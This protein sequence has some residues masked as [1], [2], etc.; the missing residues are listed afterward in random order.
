MKP[1]SLNFSLIRN[2][3]GQLLFTT[4]EG[5]AHTGI[6]PVRA[7]PISAPDNGLSLFTSNGH[8]L[9][10]LPSLDGLAA[11]IHTL[12]EAELALREFMPVIKRIKDVSSF[13]TPSTWFI[14]TN[15]GDTELVLKAEDHIRRL[16]NNRLL[17]ADR[18]SVYYMVQDIDHLD[19]HSRKLLDRFL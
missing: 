13:A 18:H 10:W 11:E 4:A 2:F 14:E 7:F 1:T 16:A 3:S 12:I 15:R 8:E 5:I 6:Y 17:V 9:A 19:K